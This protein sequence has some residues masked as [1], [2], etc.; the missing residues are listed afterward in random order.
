MH[1]K[2]KMINGLDIP[3]I[4]IICWW[5][6]LPGGSLI[7]SC[8][9]SVHHPG[10][11]LSDWVLKKRNADFNYETFSKLQKNCVWAIY[12]T[13]PFF[14]PPI[15]ELHLRGTEIQAGTSQRRSLPQ[16]TKITESSYNANEMCMEMLIS[17]CVFLIHYYYSKS[18]TSNMMDI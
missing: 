16:W 9:Y 10:T 17:H 2:I 12:K 13:G 3:K 18:N 8:C 15:L 4:F 11:C 1:S 6:V 5:S 7:H 14:F